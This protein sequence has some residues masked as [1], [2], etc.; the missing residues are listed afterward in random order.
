MYEITKERKRT[1]AFQELH[2]GLQLDKREDNYN[3]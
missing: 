2:K 1:T 3:H